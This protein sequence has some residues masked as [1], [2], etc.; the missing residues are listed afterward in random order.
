MAQALDAA[1]AP[2]AI[3][4][5]PLVWVRGH[6]GIMANMTWWTRLMSRGSVGPVAVVKG[7]APPR[8]PPGT[9]T[10]AVTHTGR[11]ARPDHRCCTPCAWW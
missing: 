10:L 11:H 6:G 8:F 7:P 2:D 1:Y 5:D 9:Y 4:H 3:F